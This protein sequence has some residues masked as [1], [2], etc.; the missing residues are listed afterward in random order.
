[1]GRGQ[2]RE[3][4]RGGRGTKPG[5]KNNNKTTKKKTK[6]KEFWFYIES[7]TQAFNYEKTKDFILNYILI[8]Y[9]KG[10]KDIYEALSGLEKINTDKWRSTLKISSSTDSLIKAR[11]DKENELIFNKEVDVW[12]RR[13]SQYEENIFNVYGLIWGMI[14]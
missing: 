10:G 12:T 6:L 13:I 9:S 3:Y 5:K 7:T 8:N 2:G 4:R 14:I 1:M 11:E